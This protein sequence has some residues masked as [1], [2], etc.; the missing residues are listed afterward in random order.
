MKY[1]CREV[2]HTQY[3]HSQI[4]HETSY[5]TCSWYNII[6]DTC[7]VRHNKSC[8]WPAY[9][10]KRANLTCMY[11][12][13]TASIVHVLV[14]GHSLQIKVFLYKQ[15]MLWLEATCLVLGM[16]ILKRQFPSLFC[17]IKKPILV[18]TITS[19]PAIN[20]ACYYYCSSW[21]TSCLFTSGFTHFLF[22][23][24]PPLPT[25]THSHYVLLLK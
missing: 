19:A 13:M 2:I 7:T 25:H 3:I 18:V 12:Y 14:R 24:L 5:N 9:P 8:L 17:I 1:N 10:P 11:M 21:T 23:S 16:F 22:H 15:S 20:N 4:S 6:Q